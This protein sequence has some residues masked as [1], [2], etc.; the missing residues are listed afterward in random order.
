MEG[1]ALHIYSQRLKVGSFWCGSE[2]HLVEILTFVL[3]VKTPLLYF[4]VSRVSGIFRSQ[5]QKPVFSV[6]VHFHTVDRRAAVPPGWYSVVSVRGFV[7]VLVRVSVLFF[8]VIR[9]SLGGAVLFD[10]D[11]DHSW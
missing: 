10:G 1:A 6:F 8:R 11:C 3:W 4:W 2:N 5:P 9:I 7:R